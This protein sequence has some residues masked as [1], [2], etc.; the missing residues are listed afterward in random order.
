MRQTAA[1]RTYFAGR[2]AIGTSYP[3]VIEKQGMWHTQKHQ[4]KHHNQTHQGG[5]DPRQSVLACGLACSEIFSGRNLANVLRTAHELEKDALDALTSGKPAPTLSVHT[6]AGISPA[7]PKFI[8][9][10]RSHLP[11][12]YLMH[13][14]PDDTCV[15]L[16]LSGADAVWAA[17]DLLLQL[18]QTRGN[19]SRQ[20][21]AV[22]DWSYHGPGTSAFGR[23]A[24]FG[25]EFKSPL[26]VQYPSPSVFARRAGEVELN[27]FHSRIYSEFENF[28]DSSIGESVGVILFE[29]QWGSSNLAQPWDSKLLRKFVAAAHDRSILVCC[30]EIMCGLGRHGHS[31][32]F[33]SNAWNIPSDAVTFGKSI[34]AGVEPL[35]GAVL[36]HGANEL[37]NARKTVMQSH[38]YAGSCSRA[39]ITGSAVLSSL[40]PGKV[41]G[42][43]GWMERVTDVGQRVLRDSVFQDLVDAS[44]GALGVHGQGFM[45]GA[46]FLHPKEEKR[47]MALSIFQHHCSEVGVLPYFVPQSG[48]FM[49]TPVLDAP[50]HDLVEAGRRLVEAAERTVRQLKFDREW[51]QNLKYQELYKRE[52]SLPGNEMI[53]LAQPFE[54]SES[55]AIKT[56]LR[57]KDKGTEQRERYKGPI[58]PGDLMTTRQREI[59]EEISRNRS[60]GVAGPFGP[61]LA[62]PE[63]AQHAQMLGKTCR[64][65]LESYDMR[66]SELA[67]LVTAIHTNAPTEWTIHVEEA[68]K[69]GLEEQ[70]IKAVKT[71]GAEMPEEV[72]NEVFDGLDTVDRVV[73]NF[74]AELNRDNHVCHDTYWE[75]CEQRGDLGAVELVGLIGYYRLV[76]MTLNTFEIEPPSA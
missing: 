50:E 71:H 76:S 75:L 56:P 48:G 24:P 42:D 27:E 11:A 61:W 43:V 29:P 53:A 18:Q 36:R 64:Y 35:A 67:I 38:T 69:H 74:S 73:Y 49:F 3:H 25:P 52:N 4:I 41:N 72:Q 5:K 46:A 26:Q 66:L 28:L 63:F 21:V 2:Q 12:S 31:T 30:D 15:S 13:G 20:R 40:R 70:I 1:A 22:A 44:C 51:S 68:R 17:V 39:L 10:L 58:K 62:N 8:D 19:T 14:K 60:T 6:S 55:F 37:G 57:R 45:W 7:L 65:D 59:Y 54:S 32:A 34:A 33:L 9:A 47:S 16:Q 23:A